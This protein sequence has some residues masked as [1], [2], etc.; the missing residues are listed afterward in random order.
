VGL[1]ADPDDAD[2]GI[3]QVV[4]DHAPAGYVSERRIDLLSDVSEGGSSAGVGARHAPVADGREEHGHHR[5]ED[6]GDDMPV[7]AIAEYAEHG[8]RRDRLN[9]DDAVQDQVPQREGAPELSRG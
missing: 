6:R 9:D 8:H 2:H 1:L 5:D 3:E 4:H 7:S